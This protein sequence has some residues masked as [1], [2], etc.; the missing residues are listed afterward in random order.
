M[1]QEGG[2]C[3]SGTRGGHLYF[4]DGIGLTRLLIGKQTDR[5]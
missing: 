4:L 5:W 3:S 1:Q 2:R